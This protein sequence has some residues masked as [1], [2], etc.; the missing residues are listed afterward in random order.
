[1]NPNN[2]MSLVETQNSV[3]RVNQNIRAIEKWVYDEIRAIKV[4]I[5]AIKDN[6]NKNVRRAQALEKILYQRIRAI[7]VVINKNIKTDEKIE[8]ELEERIKAIEDRLDG[9]DTL[10]TLQSKKRKKTSSLKL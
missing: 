6:I 10:S 7:E 2:T 3:R 5:K 1:M 4:D 9:A 8:K